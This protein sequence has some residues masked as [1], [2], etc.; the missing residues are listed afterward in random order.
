[1]GIIV[2]GLVATVMGDCVVDITSSVVVSAAQPKTIAMI[3]MN[4]MVILW[5]LIRI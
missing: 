3:A 5:L 2:V 4:T 1:V